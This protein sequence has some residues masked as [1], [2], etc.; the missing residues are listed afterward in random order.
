MANEFVD[1]FKEKIEL[2]RASFPPLSNELS[3]SGTND[4]DLSSS[5]DTF[6][7]VGEEEVRKLIKSSPSK[8]CPLDPWPTCLVKDF[9]D[10]LIT[11]ITKL[12]NLSL[13]EGIF[14]EEFKQAIVLPL[15][16]KASLPKNCFKNY[17]P[18]SNL[19][20]I[21]K[22]L[23]KVV[24]NQI[25]NYLSA[26]NLHNSKQ[27]A[28]RE[29][30]STE[31]ALLSVGN[32]INLNLAKGESTALVL[33]DLS[34]AFD[35]IDH[36]ILLGRVSNYFGIKGS[37]LKWLTSYLTNRNQLVKIGSTYSEKQLLNYGVPQGSVLGP[38][39]FTM[40][41]TPISEIIND[42]KPLEH[43]L[44]A[45]DT[46]VYVSITPTN[47]P[48]MLEILQKC[49]LS[50]QEWMAKNRLKLNPDK[51]EFI[52]FSNPS[53]R[54]SLS[55]FFPVDLLG[56]QCFPTQKVRN[57]GVIFDSDFSLS[58]HISNVTSSCYYHIRDLSRIRK[59]VSMSVATI[60]ANALVSSRLDYCNSLF[61]GLTGK[62]CY[63]LQSI[64]NTLCR[65][66]AR[67]PRRAHITGTLKKL[68]WL[69]VKQ[70]ILFKINTIT[71]KAISTGH[72]AYLQQYLQ[73][74]TCSLNTRRSSPSRKVLTEFPYRSRIHKSKKHF[75]ASFAYSAPNGWNNLPLA[76]RSAPTL[77]SFR[78][79][80]KSHLFALAY[81]P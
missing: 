26:N 67:L 71:Y 34:A 27:S 52:T 30:H 20:Y 13:A 23:E 59:Y 5:F 54:H 58:K 55:N 72:P 75:N 7:P 6:K 49:L 31:S 4:L 79:R 62:Q 10:I 15:I 16:K 19:N 73:P 36:N 60:L 70:R 65:I 66:V 46:Q 48:A 33:L 9:I 80:L 11:P 37:V 32:D 35:T 25:K 39:L 2:I 14:P 45:D 69:P 64:Q 17:R 18:V 77:A 63:R 1:F 24:A 57:L 76:V 12:L 53:K 51:T 21:S 44:Y 41:T 47:A 3:L 22:L 28:Y 8:S 68:H 74:Y 43:C 29:G 61:S 38:L 81:P 40:Y 42:Y 78:S 56:S 50:I